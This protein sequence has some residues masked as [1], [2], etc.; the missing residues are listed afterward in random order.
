MRVC[1]LLLPLALVACTA[2]SNARV[3]SAP[4]DTGTDDT[5]SPVRTLQRYH[6]QLSDAVDGQRARI[7]A[8]FGGSGKPLQMDFSDTRLNVSNACNAISGQYH[9]IDGH[10]QTRM[11]LSTMMACMDRTLQ[12]RESIIKTTLQDNPSLTLSSNHDAPQL[13]LIN[14]RGQTLTFT[15][16]PTAETRYQGPGEAMFLEVTAASPACAASARTDTSCLRVRERH[17]GTD[18]LSS[19][20][21]GPWHA[22]QQPIEDFTPQA[23][24]HYVLRLKRYSLNRSS[25]DSAAAYVLETIVESGPPHLSN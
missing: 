23:G 9:I 12:Q 16:K 15:G 8:L 13:L 21:P 3:Q 19:G 22:L 18:G 5:I 25:S 14:A 11:L 17:Y 6:W 1:L 2:V 7:D 24:V 10:L 20:T 4:A